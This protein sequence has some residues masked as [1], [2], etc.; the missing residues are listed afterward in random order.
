MSRD[1]L[2]WRCRRLLD[3][4]NQPSSA[5]RLAALLGILLPQLAAHAP[6]PVDLTL[7]V[8]T[9]G[10]AIAA[11]VKCECRDCNGHHPAIPAQCRICSVGW[12]RP[13]LTSRGVRR[14]PD[15]TTAGWVQAAACASRD[16]R[17]LNATF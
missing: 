5:A 15:H 3:R 2:S 6:V 9:I 16:T 13:A 7:T 8:I 17:T 1:R 14:R 12:S 11:I 4:L 10:A